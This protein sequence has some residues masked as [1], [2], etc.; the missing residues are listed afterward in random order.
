MRA[1]VLTGL[2]ALLALVGACSSTNGTAEASFKN[3]GAAC[4][5]C[6]VPLAGTTTGGF[7]SGSS[8]GSTGG[9]TCDS[10]TC[11]ALQV[12]CGTDGSCLSCLYAC[13]D[14]TC[15]QVSCSF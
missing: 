14:G 7:G 1:R 8:G 9:S 11:E 4:T 5:T 13:K 15:Q 3:C 10:T 12:V 2:P 6:H